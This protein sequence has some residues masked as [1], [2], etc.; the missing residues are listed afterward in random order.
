MLRIHQDQFYPKLKYIHLE[1]ESIITLI[2][3]NFKEKK[4]RNRKTGIEL[5]TS[6]ERPC[7]PCFH[8]L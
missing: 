3:K 6:F 1:I 2:N 7:A 4:K 8:S 5:R